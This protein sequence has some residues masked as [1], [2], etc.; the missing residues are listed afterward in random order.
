M[1][2][3]PADVAAV[4]GKGFLRNRGTDL[5]SGRIVA[6]GTVYSAEDLKNIAYIAE[7]YG[8]G[9][10]FAT[11]RL[12]IEIAGIPFEKIEECIAF[13]EEHN[14][15]FGG[16][17]AKI[18]PVTACKGTTCVYGNFDTQG[19][20][21]KIYDE[22]FIGWKDAALPH[23]FKIGIGG[24]PNSCMKPSLNDV[25]IEG[26]AAPVIDLE[27]CR[28]CKVCAISKACPM[29]SAS[30][31]DGKINI[32]SE[33]CLTCGVCS[34]KCPFG[35]IDPNK[36][37][38]YQIYVGG[39]WGK[40]TRM[41]TPLKKRLSE[42]EIIPTLEKIILWY[43]DNAYQKERLGMAVDRIGADKMEAAVMS[44]ELLARKEE[45]LAK[46]IAVRG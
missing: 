37:T 41:G 19:L 16:T 44:D 45:I 18:R 42:E 7:H 22:F 30:L 10:T 15:Y 33:T 21:K 43:K 26:H 11:S 40:H 8:N 31:V 13:A 32:D 35:A 17:G 36:H 23:K 34:G 27:K 46:E 4:K 28:G 39:T 38:E 12:C 14:L 2:L 24:C 6:R 20:A 9:K 25:G 5:F 3:K 1:A 29:K